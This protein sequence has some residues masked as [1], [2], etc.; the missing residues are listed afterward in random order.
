MALN[1]VSDQIGVPLEPPPS[2]WQIRMKTRI[3]PRRQDVRI[4]EKTNFNL[5]LFS[6]VVEGSLKNLRHK[7]LHHYLENRNKVEAPLFHSV[8][9]EKGKSF[10]NCP[11][12]RLLYD[13]Y[14]EA[15]N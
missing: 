12:T 4:R 14:G 3:G 8:L 10:K 13:T 6:F 2:Q 9:N 11:I 5:S 7:N 15:R 1:A